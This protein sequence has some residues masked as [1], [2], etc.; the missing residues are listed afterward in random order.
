[1]AFFLDS[2]DNSRRQEPL[3]ET[4]AGTGKQVQG[5]RELNEKVRAFVHIG[6]TPAQ[7]TATQKRPTALL[8]NV[9]IAVKDLID[10]AGMPTRLGS[11]AVSHAA[12]KHAAVITALID[13]GAAI[14]GKSHTT[15]FAMSGWGISPLGR[16][17]NPL[18]AQDTLFTGGS[19]NG[20][21]SAVAAGLV[22]AALGTDTGGS[23]RIPSSWCGITGLKGSPGW[24]S[25]QGV[26]ALSQSFDVVGP[27]ARTARDVVLLYRAMLPTRRRMALEQT[28]DAATQKALPTLIFLD[29]ASLGTLDSEVLAAYRAA[30]ACCQEIGFPAVVENIPCRFADMA[31]TWSGISSVEGYLNNRQWADD[32]SAP[33]E[34]GARNNLLQGGTTGVDEYFSLLNRA[35]CYREQ[36]E[37]LIA[38]GHVLLVPTTSTPAT[39]LTQFDGQRTLGIYTRFVNLIQGCAIAVPNGLSV[40]GRP[41]SMQFVGTYGQDAEILHAALQWQANTDWHEKILQHH[42]GQMQK[43]A[44]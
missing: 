10:V 5:L 23:V 26:A 8:A 32:P 25:T 12:T 7:D 3:P 9:P 22:P 38:P 35:R 34:E 29:D 16:P 44:G 4:N 11:R 43:L 27:M 18:D 41:T 15:E 36:M 20:S 24:V 13:E 39:A 33:L 19:S 14:V 17:L 21:A 6:D 28:L 30:Q 37:S 1:M 40:D 31:E 42:A 2:L